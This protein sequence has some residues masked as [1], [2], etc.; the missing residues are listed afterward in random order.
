MKQKDIAMITIIVFISAIIS[1][2]VSNAIFASP[3]KRQQSVEVVQPLTASFPTK[4][5]AQYFKNGFDPTEL[6]Q[7]SPNNNTNPFNSTSH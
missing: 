2:F 4:T 5:N 7:I 6:I 1:V 3:S